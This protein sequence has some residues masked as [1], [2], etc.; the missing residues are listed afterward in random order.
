MADIS[1]EETIQIANN[2][3]LNAPPGEFMEVVTDVRGLLEDDTIINDS[4]PATFRE[5]NTEQMIQVTNGNH[6]TLVTKHGEVSPGEY[7]DPRAGQIFSFDHIRQ[8]VTG[9]RGIGG[10][11]DAGV[12]SVRA[13]VDAAVDKYTKE[14]YMNGTSAVYSKAGTVIICLASSKFNPNNFWNGR[15]RSIWT[16]KI[17]GNNVTLQ[18]QLRICVHYYEDGNVQLNAEVNRNISCSG[19]NPQAT[20]DNIIKAIK[21]EEA[22]YQQNIDNSYTTMGDTTFK[23]LRRVLPITRMK[24][25]WNKIRN[26]KMGSGSR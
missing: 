7:L 14:Y 8:Q 17:S 23:A 5:Y 1:V 21:K 10:E 9:S 16:C 12:E 6:L 13:A 18:G 26:M 22:S 3:L 19:G 15:W 2:F 11:L 20:A 24:I 25:D 4:A